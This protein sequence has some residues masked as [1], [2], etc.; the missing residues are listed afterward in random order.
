MIVDKPLSNLYRAENSLIFVKGHCELYLS[1]GKV[2][3]P[4]YQGDTSVDIEG[5]LYKIQNGN[6]VYSKYAQQKRLIRKV[7]IVNVYK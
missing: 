6:I 5:C 4:G 3:D 2:F 1:D 7:M